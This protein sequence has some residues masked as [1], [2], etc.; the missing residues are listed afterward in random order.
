M[1]TPTYTTPTRG[2]WWRCDQSFPSNRRVTMRKSTRTTATDRFLSL[3]LEHAFELDWLTA[4]AFVAAFG[5]QALMEHLNPAVDLRAKLL[6][7]AAGVNAKVAKK[8]STAAAA[9]DLQLALQEGVCTPLDVLEQLSFDEMVQWLPP[10]EL[11]HFL[12][13]D[14]FYQKNDPRSRERMLFMLE[15]AQFESLLD[16]TTI[17]RAL[18]PELV[19]KVLPK[20][21]VDEVLAQALIK[22]MAGEAFSPESLVEVLPLATWLEH[23][24]L[25]DVWTRVVEGEIVS[26]T[27]WTEAP[28][29][30]EASKQTGAEAPAPNSKSPRG[31]P[32]PVS[33]ALAQD[34]EVEDLTEA[35]VEPLSAPVAASTP[36]E[37]QARRQAIAHLSKRGR[38]PKMASRLSTP[39]L[40]AIETMYIDLQGVEEESQQAEVIFEAFPNEAQL[41]DA[42]FALAETLDPK[43]TADE[44]K[45][46]RIDARGAVQLVLFEEN[47]RKHQ[48]QKSSAPPPQGASVPGSVSAP[49]P[50]PAPARKAST[51]PPPL[52]AQARLPRSK[53]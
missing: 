4:P 21:L 49:P 23:V 15:A 9:E 34:A 46:R 7:E 36:E 20:D 44:L 5:P 13:S 18:T 45:S 53:S 31:K 33:K 26:T 8:K 24:R 42:M 35:A 22:G 37:T 38:L 17:L 12:T 52:P 50:L 27:N 47:K 39:L 3:C 41:M 6:I 43:L 25:G 10:K 32:P 30:D 14:A 11:W 1:A 51:P 16:S 40:L 2:L 19:A 29:D 28:T 48:A